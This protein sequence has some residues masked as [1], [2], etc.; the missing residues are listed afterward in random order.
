[1]LDHQTF[2]KDWQD[3]FINNFSILFSREVFLGPANQITETT[4][5]STAF[6]K[7]FLRKYPKK[8][9]VWIK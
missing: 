6:S 1:M 2:A 4:S 3:L 5:G 9:K 8:V 7:G